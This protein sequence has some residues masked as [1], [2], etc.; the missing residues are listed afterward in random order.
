MA[1][2][3]NQT[4]VKE[5]CTVG[6]RR[7]EVIMW[8]RIIFLPSIPL[9]RRKQEN[10]RIPPVHT[11]TLQSTMGNLLMKSCSLMP[12]ANSVFAKSHLLLITYRQLL[13]LSLLTLFLVQSWN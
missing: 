11:M 8:Q 1:W 10:M 9:G 5:G 7:G 4:C 3:D 13:G 2:H 6:R 12:P